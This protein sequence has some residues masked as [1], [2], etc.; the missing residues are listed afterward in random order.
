MRTGNRRWSSPKLVLPAAVLAVTGLA[1]ALSPGARDFEVYGQPVSAAKPDPEIQ[2]WIASV[3]PAAVR[4]SDEKLVSFGNRSTLSSM[5]SGLPTGQGINAAADW[6]ESEFQRYSRACGGCLEV[7]RDTFTLAPQS[8]VPSP[9]TLVNVYAVLPGSDPQQAARRYLVMG[10]YDSRNTDVMD[11][12]GAA[13]GANDDA[14]GT[15][16]VLECARVLS[17]AKHPA[18][19]VFAA[20]AGEEQGL[21]GS[22][23]LAALAKQQNWQLGG[24]LNNDIVGGNTTPGDRLQDKSVVRV[25]SE[26][27]PAASTPDVRRVLEGMGAEND[28]PSRELAREVKEVAQ[29]YLDGSAA[30]LRA[31]LEFRLDRF[32]RGG[33]HASF[34]RQGFAAV[35]L[36]EWREDFN[37]QH[38]NL[39]T[40]S[41]VEYGDLVKFV[42]FDY[43]AQVA[44]LNAATLAVL[45][46]APPA[47]LQVRV[48]TAGLDN[49]STLLWR[50]D[51][52]ASGAFEIVWRETS[53]P[54]WQRFI[55]SKD[56]GEKVTG[57]EHKVT[58]PISKD[59]VI[60]GVRSVSTR[61]CAT[62]AVIPTPER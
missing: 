18:T 38:Q 46:C 27:I 12:H 25:F 31:A 33:D 5:A 32:L 37:H 36:S 51:P 52:Q 20:V 22:A 23:H 35:R 17:Q 16:V 41:G 55:S 11:T 10:H 59:N 53:A 7:K 57:P 44:R 60:F 15:A 26:A 6:I 50:A 3:S 19:L 29:S 30:P 42:D 14:S 62:P 13:P 48:S 43:V 9:T 47:P 8:R 4:A 56:A 58:L 24:V 21:Y 54:D 49:S 1:L 39:R 28:S 34:N 45:A 61:G 40:E 2:K